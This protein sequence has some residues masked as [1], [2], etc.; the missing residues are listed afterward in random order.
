MLPYALGLQRRR[1]WQWFALA[2][3]DNF[4]IADARLLFQKFQLGVMELLAGRTVLVNP[5]EPKAFF[6]ELNLQISELQLPLQFHYCHRIGGVDDRWC[7][8]Q[9]E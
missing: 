8:G 5:L 7:G 2:F 6:Q 4:Q 9:H 3:G 1:C